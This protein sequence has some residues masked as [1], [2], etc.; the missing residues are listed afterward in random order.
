MEVEAFVKKKQAWI[1]KQLKKDA[2]SILQAGQT[3]SL[4][5]QTYVLK[6]AD[7]CFTM[8]D[9]CYF[10]R[11]EKK[12]K[13]FLLAYAQ[14]FIAERFVYWSTKMG[15]D[16]LSLKFGFYKSKWGS[17]RTDTR[18][19]RLNGYLA[20]C[21]PRMIDAVIVHELCHLKFP[22]HSSRFYQEVLFWF[23]DYYK[24]YKKLR[25]IKMVRTK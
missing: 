6:E 25:S 7:S 13:A 21:S 22:N 17:C 11:D 23:P 5:G 20:L 16:S 8:D 24:E 4:L 2:A 12:W 3:I 19:I 10:C 1:A 14:D 9:S 18:E 15:Q